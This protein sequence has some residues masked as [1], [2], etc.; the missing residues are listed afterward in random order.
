MTAAGIPRPIKWIGQRSYAGRFIEGNKDVL[1]IRVSAGALDDNAPKRDLWLSPHHALYFTDAAI[2]GV[3]IEAKDLVNGVS[4]VQSEHVKKVQ[5]FHIELESHDVLIA[6]G[7]LAESFIDDDSRLMFHNADEYRTLYPEAAIEVAQYCAPRLGGGYE[8]ETVRRR[9]AQRA[10][11]LRIADEQWTGKLEGCV[12]NV[13]ARG[14]VG[15][16]QAIDHPEAPVCLDIYAGACLIGRVLA[17]RYR[18]DLAQAGVGNGCHG[19]VFTPPA[20]LVFTPETVEVRRS[21]DGAVLGRLSG[22]HQPLA[23]RWASRRAVNRKTASGSRTFHVTA[24][25]ANGANRPTPNAA[26]TRSVRAQ[27]SG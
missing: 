23:E 12:D 3:L 9:I 21:F 14:I 25:R 6:E 20:G 2:G 17:N 15:W 8:V 16:A 26:G 4:I 5:Y 18:E 7:A 10:D 24:F 1:P 13:G 19:F 27:R 22:T 11:L